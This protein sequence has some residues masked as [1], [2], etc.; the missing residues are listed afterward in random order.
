MKK[1]SIAWWSHQTT[2]SLPLSRKTV[3]QRYGVP[4]TLPSS[5]LSK[6]TAAVCGV[7]NSRR[8]IRFAVAAACERRMKPAHIRGAQVLA[9]GSG[10]TY[11]KL[12][13]LADYTCI[14]TFEGHTSSVLRL[15]FVTRG[16]QIMSRCSNWWRPEPEA[17]LV[18]SC[19]CSLSTY[20]GSDGFVKLWTIKSNECVTT[21]DGHEEGK[22]GPTSS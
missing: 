22:V 3:L 8:W 18:A 7:R 9:T 16:M 13:A 12:W 19:I 10:D 6:V 20:S 4:T 17:V 11:I 21:L 5:E 2:S 15:A 1:T 14:R